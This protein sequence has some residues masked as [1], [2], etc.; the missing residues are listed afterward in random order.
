MPEN[1]QQTLHKNTPK[2]PSLTA[3]QVETQNFT[4]ATPSKLKRPKGSESRSLPNHQGFL[5]HGIRGGKSQSH[6]EVAHNEAERRLNQAITA[7][8]FRELLQMLVM[9]DEDV[10]QRALSA[11][12]KRP[13]N[14]ILYVRAALKNKETKKWA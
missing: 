11:E 1:R 12:M 7:D 2:E 9:E 3:E 5:L 4:S 10:Y 14:G 6:S 13:D 8:P